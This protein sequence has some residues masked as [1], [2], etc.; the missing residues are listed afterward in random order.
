MTKQ[1]RAT[2]AAILVISSIS[3]Q[4][5]TSTTTK[6]PVA[7]KPVAKKAP[8]ESPVEREIRELR[9]QM[10]SQQAQID[11]LK[12]ENADKD[13]RLAA[14]QQSAQGAEA[15]AAAA[16]A[17]ADSLSSSVSANAD[18]VSTLNNSV[19]DLKATSVGMAQTISDTKK[20]FSDQLENP[21]TLR[22]KGVNITPVGFFAFESVW[23]Q[24]SLNSDVNTPFNSTPYPGAAQAHPTELNFSGRQSRLGAIFEGNTGPYRMTGFFEADFLGAG[25]TSNDNQSNSYV[26]RQRQ[27]WGQF[28]SNTGLKVTGGQMWS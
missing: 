14:A 23:R 22:Y 13:A 1:L 19:T 28:A 18:T 3:L 12:R 6:K 9:E 7:K 27:I 26:L 8:V 15:A 17:K 5:Q 21:L 25:I 20:S 24:R 11:A 4:A 2:M 10:Q 16:S